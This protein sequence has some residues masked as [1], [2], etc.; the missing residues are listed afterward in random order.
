MS[1]QE[2]HKQIEDKRNKIIGVVTYLNNVQEVAGP[3][4]KVDAKAKYAQTAVDNLLRYADE[5]NALYV[6]LYQSKEKA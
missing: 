6:E 1:T 3:F 5:L 2:L 4:L